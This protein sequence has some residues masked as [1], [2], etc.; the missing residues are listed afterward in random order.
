MA[1][2]LTA[3]G[4]VLLINDG[5]NTYPMACA[6]TTTL[7][8][9]R[10]MIELA[11]K[12]NGIFREYI[13]GRETFTASGSG[14]VKLVQSAMHPMSFFDDFILGTDTSYSCR[15]E[16]TDPQ[17]NTQKYQFTCYISSLTLES[18]YGATPTYSYTLQGT[19]PITVYP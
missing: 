5:T 19:G 6:K 13:H 18:T 2:V 9:E 10:E 7:T 15:F 17:S 3:S 11:P 4:M 16:M 14:L 12:T 8:I 1:D